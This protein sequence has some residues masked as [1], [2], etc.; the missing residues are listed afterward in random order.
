MGA[1]SYFIHIIPQNVEP[2]KIKGANAFQ[3]TT[4]LTVDSLINILSSSFQIKH[5]QDKEYIVNEYWIISF[6]E[7][8]GGFQALTVEGCFTL[9]EKGITVI[10]ELAKLIDRSIPIFIYH[11]YGIKKP[12]TSEQDL[13]SVMHQIYDQ[14]IEQFKELFPSSTKPSLPRETFYQSLHK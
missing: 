6:S 1:E 12:I 5:L 2:I 4:G 8:T 13:G 7:E 9:F 14:K 11:P 10:F 3:G